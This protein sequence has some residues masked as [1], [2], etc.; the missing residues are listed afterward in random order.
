MALS[1][2]SRCLFFFS[3]LHYFVHLFSGLCLISFLHPSFI[4][5]G[6]FSSTQFLW[7]SGSPMNQ[8]LQL[9]RRIAY[10]C[11]SKSQSLSVLSLQLSVYSL[12]H[13]PA[14]KAENR[15][16]RGVYF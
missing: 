5:L 3:S 15:K 16:P 4:I 9:F 11:A 10:T 13:M 2:A 7:F 6:M 14:V 8:S 1:T 12:A